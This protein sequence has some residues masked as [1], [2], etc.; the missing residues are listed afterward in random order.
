[1]VLPTRRGRGTVSGAAIAQARERLGPAP[2]AARFAQTAAVSGP[3]AAAA[4][5][6]RGPTVFGVEGAALRGPRPRATC[7]ACARARPRPP[8]A[9]GRLPPAASGAALGVAA[10]CAAGAPPRPLPRP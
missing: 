2:L 7:G 5:R 3:A 6:W 9:R 4:E 8:G 10:A 1:L